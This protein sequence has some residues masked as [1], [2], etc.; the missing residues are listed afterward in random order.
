MRVG[1]QVKCPL[2][3]SDLTRVGLFRQSLVSLSSIEFQEHSFTCPRVI[4]CEQRED[5][6]GEANRCISKCSLRTSQKLN[7]F[8]SIHSLNVEYEVM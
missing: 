4:A 7:A 6:H 8:E 5:R 1:L 3:L 2:L